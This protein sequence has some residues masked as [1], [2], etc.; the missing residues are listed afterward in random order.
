MEGSSHSDTYSPASSP[1]SEPLGSWNAILS[2]FIASWLPYAAHNSLDDPAGVVMLIRL[3]R[4]PESQKPVRCF[5][6]EVDYG[7]IHDPHLPDRAGR[8]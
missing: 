3:G 1:S 8:V 4:P 7:K 5:R 6:A 2:D